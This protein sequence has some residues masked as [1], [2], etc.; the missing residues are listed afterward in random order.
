MTKK[1][2]F[3][4]TAHSYDDDRI[5]YHQACSLQ[6]NGYDVSVISLSSECSGQKNGINIYAEHC[7]QASVSYKTNRIVTHLAHIK[8]GVLICSEPLAIHAA[9]IYKKKYDQKQVSIVYDITEWYPSRSQ[10]QH[11][12][13]LFRWVH[14]ALLFV[15]N[16]SA[17]YKSQTLIYGELRKIA[18]FQ[19]LFPNKPCLELPYFPH[20]RYISYVENPLH[21][22]KIC[23]F[24]AGKISEQDGV[25]RFLSA[26]HACIKKHASISVSIR[27]IG[28]YR[29]ATDE[30]KL[31]ECIRNY[32]FSDCTVLPPVPFPE[33]TKQLSAAHICFDL[34]HI[35]KKLTHSLPIKLFYYMACGIPVIYSYRQSIPD[36]F[37]SFAYGTLVNPLNEQEI[38][39][40]IESYVFNQEKHTLHSIA[41]RRAFKES[42]NWNIIEPNFLTFIQ[43]MFA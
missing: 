14:V 39:L 16:I 23:L 19:S 24:Y 26:A 5:F 4:T 18:F 31:W 25:F 2:C 29:Q 27:I 33:F 12:H 17:V 10:T 13:F 43:N 41:G 3:V 36:F 40:A 28:S 34:R 30:Q 7:L 6:Q 37:G 8:P 15:Y 22:Q 11:T 9:F 42:Y 1:I 20:E 32:E 38:V 21:P 35:Q